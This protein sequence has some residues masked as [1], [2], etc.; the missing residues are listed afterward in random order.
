MY[1]WCLLFVLAI[2]WQCA[3]PAERVVIPAFYHWQ[4]QVALSDTER[5]LLDSLVVDRLYLK[6]FDLD[7]S[8]QYQSAVPLANV[9]AGAAPLP[10]GRIVPTVFITNR[11]FLHTAPDALPELAVR[12]AD[13]LHALAARFPGAR[14][15]EWQFDC[16]WTPGTRDRYFQ[17]L[18]LI[19]VR[20]RVPVSATIRLHQVAYPVKTGVPPVDRGMLMYYNTGELRDWNTEN[21]IL[22]DRTAA[23]YLPRLEDYP[24]P[25]DVALPVF[26]WGVVF[27]PTGAVQLL[28]NLTAADIEADTNIVW[29]AAPVRAEVRAGTYLRGSYVSAGDRIRL[30]SITPDALGRAASRLRSVATTD[31]L[32]VVFYQLDPFVGEAYGAAT[33]RRIVDAFE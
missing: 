14:V 21:S 26:R 11:T 16:D 33:L 22:E 27:H 4:T 20:S 5:G 1:R 18:E 29:T 31:T 9:R 32:R 8:E 7:W 25:L 24:L 17:F 13:K 30:E 2:G 12:V 28:N 3:P 19:A 15:V 6:F 10:V 23:A